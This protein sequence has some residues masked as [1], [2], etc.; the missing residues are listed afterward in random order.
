MQQVMKLA[1]AERYQSDAIL[2]ADSDLV[3]VRPFSA[4]D[5]YQGDLLR[6]WR[7]QRGP[8]QRTDRRYRNWYAMA[9]A[10]CQLEDPDAIN[11][12]YIAQLT[13]WR[14]E[15]V[16]QL[17]RQI[18]A[19]RNSGWLVRLLRYIDFSEFVLYGVFAEHCLS[20]QH[21]HYLDK[22]NLCHS[23]WFFDVQTPE[24]VSSF[25]GQMS[26]HQVAVHLQSNLGMSADMLDAIVAPSVYA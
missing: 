26:P 17:Y 13:S 12:S 25:I 15:N 18:E 1:M 4:L 3:F 5:I 9:A 11:G 19:G 24:D 7:G 22:Q 6:L 2:F 14:H 10:V 23:S 20:A 21:G 16:V 8:N